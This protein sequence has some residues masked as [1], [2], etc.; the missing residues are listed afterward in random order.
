MDAD[1]GMWLSNLIFIP[2]SVIAFIAANSEIK[3][4]RHVK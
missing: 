2:I 4:G 1:F 3:F